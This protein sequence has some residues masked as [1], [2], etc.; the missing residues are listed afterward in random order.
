MK[1]IFG[2]WKRWLLIL[3]ISLIIVPA[4]NKDEVLDEV[5]DV[6]VFIWN[7]LRQ[8]YLW[9]DH[10]P[11]LDA[12]SYANDAELIQFLNNFNG[13]R[14]ELF[15]SLLYQ[16]GTIDKWS[17][18]MD[19]YNDLEDLL[20]GITTSTG[21][22]FGLDYI[23]G[24]SGD[25]F[26]YVRY[27]V[28]D[29]PADEAGITRGK[30]FLQINGQ[31]IT[32][33]NYRELIYG[34]ENSYTV[35]F[36]EFNGGNLELTGEN[37]QLSKITIDEDPIHHSEIIDV[38][39]VNVAYLVYNGFT[40]PYDFDLND[41]FAAYKAAG[42]QELILD[43][44]YNGG[45]SVRTAAYLASMIYGTTSRDVFSQ[46]VYNDLVQ[47]YLLNQYGEDYFINTFRADL[48]ETDDD[49][50]EAINTLGLTKVYILTSGSSA[51][52][53][54]LLIN[55]LDPYMDVVTIGTTT[56]GKYVG[57]VTIKDYD[58]EGDL[59]RS[60]RWAMQPIVFKI[61]NSLGVSDYSNG[62]SPDIEVQEDMANILP[63]GDE[64]EPL[65]KA[66]IDDIKG[67]GSQPKSGFKLYTRFKDSKDLRP[68][69]KEMYDHI[70]LK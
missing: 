4:C 21:M 48:D 67:A 64:N 13:D 66:A 63:F 14:Y 11:E 51:S 43:L 2:D 12:D 60:H 50:Q 33:S 49:P 5:S 39:G 23:S 37:T 7:G 22:E 44:R 52:A 6:D 25:L 40:S 18:I 68:F 24:N 36:A 9:V 19:D 29:S 28:P 41:E 61:S 20:N 8:Y 17:W 34:D 15:E 59:N 56:H 53:S 70:E 38:D 30:L 16:R 65:F 35:N 58:G 47:E 31:A 3:F 10:I 32:T 69:G 42:V 55:G 46:S 1:N 27:V 54:E 26:G 45:G 62:L 57:S